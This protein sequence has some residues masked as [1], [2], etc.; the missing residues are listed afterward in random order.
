MPVKDPKELFVMMLSDVRQGTE[1]TTKIFQEMS[2]IVQ[3]PDIKEALEARVFVSHKILAT[4]DE[5][6]RLMGEQPVKLTG[7]LHD[8]FVEDFRKELAEIQSSVAK[9]LFILAKL[10]H[11]IHLRIAEYVTLIATADITG[12][13]AVGLLL[14]TCLADKLAFV[15]RT[16]RLLGNIVEAKVAERVA[17]RVAAA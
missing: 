1:R 3:D 6:F 2:T 13:Y 12:H 7:R 11:L 14:E 8:V 15:E 9:H 5:C 16:R 4:L 10:N 17:K